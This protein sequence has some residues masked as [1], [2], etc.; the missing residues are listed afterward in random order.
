MELATIKPPYQR[1]SDYFG[2][3]SM[4]EPAFSGLFSLVTDMDLMDHVTRGIGATSI[5][6]RKMRALMGEKQEDIKADAAYDVSPGGVA[7]VSLTGTLM[8]AESSFSSSTSTV[9]ARQAIRAASRDPNVSAILMLIDSP[10]GTVAGTNDLAMEIAAAEKIKPTGAFCEDLCASAAYW[11]AS[12]AGLI[13]CNPTALVG[14]IGT[15]MAVRDSSAQADAMKVKVHVIKA[16]DFKGAGTPGTKITD[17]QIAAWQ[18]MVNALNAQFVQGVATGRKMTAEKA[19]GLADG[20]VHVGHDAKSLG[21]VDAVQSL[22]DTV[23]QLQER[24]GKQ[25]NVPKKGTKMT[26]QTT[27]TSTAAPLE[28]RSTAATLGELK[29]AL[30]GADADFLLKQ[31]DGNV[32]LAQAQSNWIAEM[33]TRLEASQKET[34]DAKA[35]TG[36]HPGGKPLGAG[37]PPKASE[38]ETGS[39]IA[40]FNELVA[41]IEREEKMTH[42][43]AISAA[44]RRNP[45]LHMNFLAATN[46]G[47]KSRRLLN[48][49][50]G[51]DA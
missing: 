41:K 34:A 31:L 22:D 33:N 4:Y 42:Q 2:V 48:E 10:G 40:D 28:L 25:G 39:P 38:S 23:R 30:K 47:M 24:A 6:E 14:S 50:Y 36:K 45:D 46:P 29:A 9:K 16:G 20:R 44:A 49:K 51:N 37:T 26:E 7:I 43:K 32:T 21:L 19:Q 13:A 27:T 12:Q 8:K 1:L 18:E 3:W 5:D 35:A 15:Y 17:E 11:C